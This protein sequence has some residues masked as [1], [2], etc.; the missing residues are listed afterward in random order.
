MARRDLSSRSMGTTAHPRCRLRG[1]L[2]PIIVKPDGARDYL[3]AAAA[4]E[5]PGF[6]RSIF[7]DARQH[8]D[9]PQRGR[10][11]WTCGCDR[12]RR[13]L[14]EPSLV[15]QSSITFPPSARHGHGGVRGRW[16]CLVRGLFFCDVAC[17]ACG[18]PWQYSQA[19]GPLALRLNSVGLGARPWDWGAASTYSDR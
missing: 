7:G 13:H 12:C 9:Q 8:F 4:S 17:S 2:R 18:R 1:Y 16:P 14:R 10:A 15:G 3:S 5:C 6:D 19:V 11:A